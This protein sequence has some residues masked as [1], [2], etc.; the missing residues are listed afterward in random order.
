MNGATTLYPLGFP[1][2]EAAGV[3]KLVPVP[4]PAAGADWSTTVP[5][6]G[7]WLVQAFVA[8]LTNAVAAAN[9]FPAVSLTDGNSE[10]FRAP[11]SAAVIASTVLNASGA[12][13]FLPAAVNV[14][15]GPSAVGLPQIILPP[16]SV[17]RVVTTNLQA[18]DQWSAIALYVFEMPYGPTGWPRGP[19]ATGDP[20]NVY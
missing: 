15:L 6:Q 1:I 9:R 16:G 7:S 5:G 12:I 19:V 17:F 4:T 11:L 8:T 2:L 13:G 18:A 20:G 10:Y 14:T 3:P